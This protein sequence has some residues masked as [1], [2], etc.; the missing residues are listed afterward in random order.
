MKAVKFTLTCVGNFISFSYLIALAPPRLFT[1]NYFVISSLRYF[2]LSRYVRKTLHDFRD[3]RLC[4]R[5]LAVFNSQKPIREEI[6]T[7][8]II[9]FGLLLSSN[10][11]QRA[12]GRVEDCEIIGIFTT[13][14]TLNCAIA[15]AFLLLSAVWCQV[16]V[17]DFDEVK[18]KFNWMELICDCGHKEHV[19]VDSIFAELSRQSNFIFSGC[20]RWM[21]ISNES[22]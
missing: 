18:C 7:E 1:L 5:L 14:K 12:G 15:S 8:R 20:R 13:M 10:R 19:N 9:L 2:L 4:G 17:E 21:A 3:S 22:T 6:I 16:D 11:N